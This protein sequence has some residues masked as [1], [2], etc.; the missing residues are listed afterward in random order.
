MSSS[1]NLISIESYT[2]LP[3]DFDHI[4]KKQRLLIISKDAVFFAIKLLYAYQLNIT[5]KFFK[6]NPITTLH[7]SSG[8]FC[9]LIISYPSRPV[10]DL[11]YTSYL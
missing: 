8:Q 7:K 2:I 4:V 11:F 5:D 3:T 1:K 6:V 9:H 10:G